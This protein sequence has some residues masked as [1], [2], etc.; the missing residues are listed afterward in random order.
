MRSSLSFHTLVTMK[1]MYF[2]S[3]GLYVLLALLTCI[4]AISGCES[5]SG[6]GIPVGGI[7]NTDP[8]HGYVINSTNYTIVID[9]NGQNEYQVRIQPGDLLAMGLDQEQTHLL[10]VIMLNDSGQAVAEYVNSFY[11]NEIALDNQVRDFVCSW[12]AE[13]ISTS[14][15]ANRFGS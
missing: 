6:R 3:R 10:H 1:H 14:G 12:Y 15:Y 2:S 5:E 8:G 11:I 9:V 13:V 7:P 4:L